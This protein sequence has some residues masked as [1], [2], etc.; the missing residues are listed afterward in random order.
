MSEVQVKNQ[1]QRQPAD[2]TYDRAVI[3]NLRDQSPFQNGKRN[4]DFCNPSLTSNLVFYTHGKE[5]VDNPHNTVAKNQPRANG[6]NMNGY[7]AHE[8]KNVRA[9]SNPRLDATKASQR[10][11]YNR[12]ERSYHKSASRTE[13][14][15]NDLMSTSN[16]TPKGSQVTPSKVTEYQHVSESVVSNSN[17]LICDCCINKRQHD[18]KLNDKNK[19]RERDNELAR[20]ANNNMARLLNEEKERLLDQKRAFGEAALNNKEEAENFKKHA[21]DRETQEAMRL[22]LLDEQK[23]RELTNAEKEQLR[24]MKDTYINGLVNQI[25]SKEELDFAR[26]ERELEDERRKHNILVHG[27]I[28]EEMKIKRREEYM[29]TIR[30]QVHDEYQR[31]IEDLQGRKL[32]ENEYRRRVKILEEEERRRIN[33]ISSNKKQN[34]KV[35]LD[36]QVDEKNI[37]RSEQQRLKQQEIDEHRARA[38]DERERQREQA[39]LKKLQTAEHLDGLA[40]QFGVKENNVKA[41]KKLEMVHAQNANKNAQKQLEADKER[42]LEKKRA[43]QDAI[44]NQNVDKMARKQLERE[45][46]EAEKRREREAIEARNRDAQYYEREANKQKKDAFITDLVHQIKSKEELEQI[47]IQRELDAERNNHN[48]IISGE[49]THEMKMERKAN[50]AQNIRTQVQLDYQRKVEELNGRRL[51]ETEHKRLLKELHEEEQRKLRDIKDTNKQLL[52]NDIGRQLDEKNL[53]KE[54]VDGLR[55]QDDEN[56]KRRVEA[57]KQQY[58]DN[59]FRKKR[60]NEEHLENLA[61]QLGDKEMEKNL[62][63]AEDLKFTSTTLGLKEKPDKAYECNECHKQYPLKMLN[64]KV[65][66]PKRKP[67]S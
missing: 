19:Q 42:E 61:R 51:E 22:R 28:T 11:D 8:P 31:K 25:K 35:M 9:H 48:L 47:R 26:R 6:Y 37:I 24:L 27:E 60:Q 36:G 62:Q 54:Q 39:E 23:N 7:V 3:A 38:E 67:V 20:R 55:R 59:M 41:Q 32:E 4:R 45:T 14:K 16:R 66:V 34:L 53:I 43:Y 5:K 12:P 33:E 17:N 18:K 40:N 50:Y 64:K 21:K 52:K 1:S 29:Q 65:K 30:T 10:S 15:E 46:E 13:P 63:K 56:F 2:A 49:I 44:V 57:E 58:M